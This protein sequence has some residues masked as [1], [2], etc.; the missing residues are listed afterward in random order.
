MSRLPS[1]DWTAGA[2]LLIVG[3]FFLAE[4]LVPGL[5]RFIPLL[6]GL[7]L[8]G[9]FLITRSAGALV[10]G[11][12]LTGIGVGTI[13]AT[14]PDSPY[15]GG[16]FL[17]STGAGFMVVSLLAAMYQLRE[18]RAWPLVPG[19]MLVAA[20]V[21]II[22]SNQ[23]QVML[24]FAQTWW[25]AVLLIVGAWVLVGA[26]RQRLRAHDAESELRSADDRPEPPRRDAPAEV[27]RPVPLD[28]ERE[29]GS[30]SHHPTGDS[31]TE[32]R[33]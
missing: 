28:A 7:G 32:T 24:Q 33:S 19:S 31:T 8:I 29:A 6:V 23:G 18:A 20:G 9:L 17:I 3:S 2:L 16:A 1:R 15:G 13:V 5:E 22:A 11:G 26:Q 27:Q 12:V 25:P 10:P 21:I 14:Q 4:R 30:E